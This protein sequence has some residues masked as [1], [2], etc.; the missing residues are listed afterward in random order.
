[1][2]VEALGL[3]DYLVVVIVVALL[4]LLVD[5]HLNEFYVLEVLAYAL[6]EPV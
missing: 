1:M 2:H 6:E 3:Y 4:M 5:L